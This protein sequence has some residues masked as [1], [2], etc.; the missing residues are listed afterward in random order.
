MN[1]GGWDLV[2]MDR[3]R[4]KDCLVDFLDVLA[5]EGSKDKSKHP[6]HDG[7]C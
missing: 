4:E 2:R 6:A 1:Q 7:K 5:Q 3:L